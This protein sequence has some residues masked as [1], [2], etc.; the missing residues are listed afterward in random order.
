MLKTGLLKTA[1]FGFLLLSAALPSS[2]SI[3]MNPPKKS[4]QKST[5]RLPHNPP[6]MTA[7]TY[8]IR[9]KTGKATGRAV[10]S[11]DGSRITYLDD[12]GNVESRAT[13]KGNKITIFDSHGKQISTINGR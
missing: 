6:Q 2:V 10:V 9:D 12:H 11:G 13:V 4:T 5:R 7:R 1:L 3:A 8:T